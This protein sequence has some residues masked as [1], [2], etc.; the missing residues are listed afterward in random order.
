MLKDHERHKSFEE[1]EYPTLAQ[2]APCYHSRSFVLGFKQ[3]FA[4]VEGQGIVKE[5]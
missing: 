4:I 1:V 5:R 3:S 2:Y